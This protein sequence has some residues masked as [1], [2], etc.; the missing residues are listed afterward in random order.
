MSGVKDRLLDFISQIDI[1]VSEFERV[2]E[3][4]NG[5]VRNISKSIQP[6][7]L[8]KISDNYPSL[9]IT[10]L[11]IGRG[12]MF[13]SEYKSIASEVNSGEMIP[14]ITPVKNKEFKG[15]PYYNVDFIGGFD[16][17]LEDKTVNP[18]YCID[19]PPYNK[20]DILWC[21]LF[22]KSMEPYIFSGDRIAIK[23][24]PIMDVIFGK[25][26]GVITRGGLRTVKWIV[27]SPEVGC[28]RL[29]PENKDPKFGDY[30]DVKLED[31]F[32]VFVVMGAV[33]AF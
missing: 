9:D 32:K 14:S 26:Y 28:Y 12:E 5:Y 30:Q 15:A 8:E 2:I 21:N 3:V 31:I 27:R 25:V 13:R 1:P 6:Y 23:E 16:L 4:S 17:V 18:E 19:L 33:R 22:G 11:L 7:V 10:W 20:P 29:V 24:V